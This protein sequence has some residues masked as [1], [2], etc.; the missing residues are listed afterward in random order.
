MKQCILLIAC[1]CLL[2]TACTK[3]QPDSIV[4][5]QNDTTIVANGTDTNSSGNF[6]DTSIIRA[7]DKVTYE[8][9][10]EDP[11]GWFGIWNDSTG[12]L[13]SN[14]L[15]S[16][17]YGS[18]K[19]LPSG[20]KY[21]FTCP[22]RPFQALISV[23]GNSWQQKTRVNLY[24]NN[25]L[26]Q[27]N[28]DKVIPAAARLISTAKTDSLV[29]TSSHPVLTYE[30]IISND[31]TSA[32]EH[33]AW[34]GQWTVSADGK[35]DDYYDPLLSSPLPIPSGWRYSFYADALPFTMA[36]GVG[37][38]TTNTSVATLRFYVNGQLVKSTDTR[39]DIYAEDYKYVVQ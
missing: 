20:W 32:F 39:T 33:D 7:G 13:T 26:I 18:P 12:Q 11:T 5:N 3:W 19:L 37:P 29:G 17:A 10:T 2:I 27:S 38:I 22:N 8:V 21:S 16:I 23:A 14:G 1:L 9:I 31:D 34:F 24:K 15:D 25:H 6:K 28:S 36:M 30:V 4:T 35:T